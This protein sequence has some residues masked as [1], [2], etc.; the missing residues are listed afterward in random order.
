MSDSLD[1]VPRRSKRLLIKDKIFDTEYGYNIIII[2]GII[3]ADC[4]P[5]GRIKKQNKKKDFPPS[6]EFESAGGLV[7]KYSPH[8][9]GALKRPREENRTGDVK[10]GDQRVGLDGT[11]VSPR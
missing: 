11:S 6:I 10:L 2:T 9:R 5:G 7:V 8:T 4:N 3:P 1:G